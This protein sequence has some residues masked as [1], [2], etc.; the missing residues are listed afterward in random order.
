[1]HQGKDQV[2]HK[3]VIMIEIGSICVKTAGREAGKLCVAVKKMDEGF[4]M[5]TGPKSLSGVKR[6]RCNVAH[7]EPM[8][9]KVKIGSDA[10][11]DEVSKAIKGEGLEV[12]FKEAIVR[13]PIAEPEPPK[14]EA[15]SAEKPKSEKKE[16]KAEENPTKAAPKAS[17]KKSQKP[18]APKPTAKPETKKV[19]KPAVNTSAKK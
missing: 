3:R 8:N 19:D 14:A 17:P 6:R 13:G 11:D 4:M 5:I 12:R 2:S 7:L 15:K 18:K 10:S 9:V 16:S 1:M